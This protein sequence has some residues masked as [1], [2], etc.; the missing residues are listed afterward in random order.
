MLWQ[1]PLS[2]KVI[3]DGNK[4]LRVLL[5]SKGR[6]IIIFN[7][8]NSQQKTSVPEVEGVVTRLFELD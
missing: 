1:H 5:L 3:S 2:N 4:C 6:Q 8:L 7:S